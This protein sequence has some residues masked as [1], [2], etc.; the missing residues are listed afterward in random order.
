[1]MLETGI[2]E[3]THIIESLQPYGSKNVVQS[4][5]RSLASR[6]P[7]AVNTFIHGLITHNAGEL[8]KRYVASAYVPA[9]VRAPGHATEYQPYLSTYEYIWRDYLDGKMSQDAIVAKLVEEFDAVQQI[10]KEREKPAS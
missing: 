1:M 10:L 7:G 3:A 9:G 6:D 5:R 4:L 8:V 2:H